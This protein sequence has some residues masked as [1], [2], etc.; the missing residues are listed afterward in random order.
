MTSSYSLIL[1]GRIVRLNVTQLVTSEPRLHWISGLRP[2]T[3]DLAQ[4][5]GWI[6][7]IGLVEE[8]PFSLHYG[9]CLLLVGEKEVSF[10]KVINRLSSLISPSGWFPTVSV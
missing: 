2:R 4:S 1:W 10:D 3:G 6:C 8:H 5:P 7:G 9:A